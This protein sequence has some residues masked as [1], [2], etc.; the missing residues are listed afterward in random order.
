MSKDI[1]E[2]VIEALGSEGKIKILLTL[3]Q[4]PLELH[5]TYTILKHT[6]LRRQDANRILKKLCAI[7]WVKQHQYG[8][9]KYQLNIEKE[10]VRLL[11]NYLKSIEAI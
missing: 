6:G 1:Q 11:I 10:E 9:K 2:E 4:K 7:R 3:A 8:V 5:T